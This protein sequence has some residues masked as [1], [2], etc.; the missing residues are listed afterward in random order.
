MRKTI[1]TFRRLLSLGFAAVLALWLACPPAMAEAD[2]PAASGYFLTAEYS[3][4][5]FAP[6]DGS[7]LSDLILTRNGIT[8][9]HEQD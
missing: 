4:L 8:P 9:L 7:P 5:Y 6:A 2:A 1:F 3:R